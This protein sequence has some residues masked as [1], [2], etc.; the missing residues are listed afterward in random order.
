MGKRIPQLIWILAALKF[1]LPFLLQHPVYELH[2]DEYLYYAQGQHLDFGFLEC[3]PLLALLGAIS[4][5]LGGSF[6]WIKFWPALFGALMLLVTTRIAKELG[7]R[8]F[9]QLVAALSVLFS[10]YLRTNF[11]FQPNFLEHFFWTLAAYYLVRCITTGRYPYLYLF[12]LALAASWWS[13]YS[14]LFFAAAFFLALLLSPQRR[15]LLQKHF[16]L[17][18]LFGVVLILPN[19]AWQWQHNW[20]LAHHMAE[21]RDTQLQYLS[22]SDFIKEQL[23]MLFPVAFVWIG[24]FIWL[25][26]QQA[27]RILALIYLGVVVLL[28]IGSGKGYYTLGAYPMLLAAGGVWLERMGKWKSWIR[29]ATVAL[30]LLLSIPAIPLL[31]PM[32]APQQMAESNK[33]WGLEKLGLL[34]WEDQEN[35]LLQQDFADMQGWNELTRKAEKLYDALPTFSKAHTVV[36]CRHYG[37]AGALGYYARSDDF[38]NKVITDNGTFLL[39]IPLP[40]QMQHMIFVGRDM[41]GPDDKVFQHFE[42]ATIIDSVTNPFSRQYGDKIIFFQNA[43][44]LAN[45]FA[46]DGLKKMK[47]AFGR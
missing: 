24:G 9:A 11:L 46:V 7:G 16:W 39:W 22:K 5:L 43:D 18:A 13:K 31:L 36:F 27:Y 37:Q 38:R 17:A 4:A 1:G 6:F 25:L 29:Y 42:K 30:I 35:H 10:A 40:L 23:L 8:L 26:R 41:P 14:L 28:L 21:L 44:S 33:E 3:P 45:Q 32:Q 20:P 34:K 12:S 19:I 15:W 47:A 2:R